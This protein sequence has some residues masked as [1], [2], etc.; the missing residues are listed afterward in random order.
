MHT[1]LLSLLYLYP[2]G[3]SLLPFRF[4]PFRSAQ[5]GEAF[6]FAAII[7]AIFKPTDV[8]RSMNDKNVF[9]TARLVLLLKKTCQL[10]QN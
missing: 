9:G 3:S 10:S 6:T 8:F 7:A 4:A 1:Q 5:E 2:P